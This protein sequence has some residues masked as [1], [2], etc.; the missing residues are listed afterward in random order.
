MNNVLLHQIF[1]WKPLIKK[2]LYRYTKF[3][4]IDNNQHVSA[5]VAKACGRMLAVAA[6]GDFPEVEPAIAKPLAMMALMESYRHQEQ[7]VFGRLGS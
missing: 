1:F 6:G 4:E 7:K 2:H 5:M 3:L